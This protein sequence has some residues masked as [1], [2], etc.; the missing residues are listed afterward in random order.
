MPYCS[1]CGSVVHDRDIYC[2]SCGTRQPDS[3][4]AQQSGPPPK[5]PPPFPPIDALDGI[6]PRIACILCYIPVVGWIAA[7]VVL[8]ARRFRTNAAVRFHAFQGLYLFAAWLFVDWAVSPIF[9]NMHEPFYRVDKVLQALIF[10]ASIF[11][12]VKCAH[13]ETYSLPIIGELAQR[14]ATEAGNG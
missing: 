9:R 5:Q 4:A 1:S 13:E 14:S 2:A 12:I 7:V 8:A 3:G 10:A 11:M 6:P